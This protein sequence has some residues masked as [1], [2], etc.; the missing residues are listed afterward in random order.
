[1]IKLGMVLIQILARVFDNFLQLGVFY[2]RRLLGFFYR[3]IYNRR[4]HFLHCLSL[5]IRVHL[6]FEQLLKVIL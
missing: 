2:Q 6:Q 4:P 3:L 1:M 5:L